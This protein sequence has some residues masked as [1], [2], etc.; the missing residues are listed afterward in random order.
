MATVWAGEMGR[1]ASALLV[2]ASKSGEGDDDAY[3]SSGRPCQGAAPPGT[4]K[5]ESRLYV[6]AKPH[7]SWLMA[8]GPSTSHQEVHKQ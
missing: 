1:K 2:E 4:V 6:L 3:E 7:G 8:Q 5:T